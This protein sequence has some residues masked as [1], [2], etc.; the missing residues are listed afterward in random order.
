MKYASFTRRNVIK[1]G[2]GATSVAALGSGMELPA[3]AATTDAQAEIP[4]NGSIDTP[5]GKLE[6]VNG[7]P[8]DATVTKLYDEMDFQRAVQAYLWGLPYVAMGQWQEEQR[9]K[10][11]AQDLQ[12]VD[13]FDFKDKLGLLTANATTPYSMAFPNLTKTGPLVFEFPEGAIA[14]GILD[15]GSVLSPI[16]EPWVRTSRSAANISSSDLTTLT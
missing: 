3:M 9:T 16:P 14:G 1:S 5:I 6:V 12:Y 7:Y 8:T 4:S 2:I 10:F 13:Y 15:S 11:G